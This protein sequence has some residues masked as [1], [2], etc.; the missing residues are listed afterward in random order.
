MDIINQPLFQFFVE[1]ILFLVLTAIGTFI[2]KKIINSDNKYLNPE[3]FL[4]QDEIHTLKQVLY[5]IMMA[6]CFAN[7][8][9]SF[10]FV[11]TDYFYLTLFDIALSLAIAIT[12]DKST[13]KNK[14]L[15]IL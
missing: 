12:I 11:S 6:L 9:Y 15:F 2:Y 5:L 8:L 1:L 10:I 3:E 7:L 4:P 13:L 14:V